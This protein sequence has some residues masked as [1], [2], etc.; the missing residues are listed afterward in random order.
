MLFLTKA[1]NHTINEGG[2]YTTCATTL[3]DSDSVGFYQ[4]NE[5]YTI[6][7]CSDGSLQN[8]SVNVGFGGLFSIDPSDTL[9]IYDGN[10]TSAPL[11]GAYNNDN[12][13]VGVASSTANT[14]GCLTFHFVSDGAVTDTGW[15]A[16]INCVK[17]CQPIEPVITTTPA[18][19]NYG[20][21]SSY[22][23]ICPDDT[24]FFSA[25]GA[26]PH[27]GINAINYAQS[28]ATSTFEWAFGEGT[29]LTAQTGS[30][31]YSE[32]GYAVLLTVTD[33]NN[34]QEQIIHKIR[35]G[36]TPSF[37]GISVVPDTACFGD[38]VQLNGGFNQIT[39]AGVGFTPSTGAITAGGTVT[40]QT[41]LPDGDGN[42]YSTSVSISGFAGQNI[43][44][45]TDIAEVCMNIEHSYLGDLQF[46]LTCPNGTT[47]MLSDNYNGSGGGTYLGDAFDPISPPQ[48]DTT[49]GVG[50]DYCFT[51]AATWGTM[52][53]ENL[54]S[55][56]IP[57][58]VTPGNNILSP[59][60]FQPEQSFNDLV[61]CPIDGNWTIT[62][63]DNLLSDNG[64]IFE[65]GLTL[66]PAI[67]PN[68]EFYNVA[69]ADGFWQSSPDI[70]SM[71]DTMA[72]AAPQT[73]GDNQYTFQI[74]DEYGCDFDTTV[75]VFV[76]Q[77][78][79][80][81]ATP[82]TTI[83]GSQLVNLN[84]GG[85]VSTCDYTV[86]LH[87]D[88]GDGWN[89][90]LVDI[91]INGVVYLGAQTVLDCSGSECE[92]TII[93]PVTTGDVISF[94]YTSGT[95]DYENTITVFDSEG[96][97][98]F[99]V[100]DPPVGAQGNIVADCAGGLGFSWGP[101][102]DLSD[103]TLPNPVFNGLNTQSYAVTMF[104][105]DHPQ[106][107]VLSDSITIEVDNQDLPIIT[108]DSAV[109][110][111]DPVSFLITGA[112]TITWPDNS[113]DSVYT[114][115]PLNDDIVTVTAS[116]VCGSM[117][118]NKHV[119]VYPE[120]NITAS[121]DTVVCEGSPVILNLNGILDEC[122]FLLT[123]ID[124]AGNG[125]AG[126]EAVDVKING[127]IYE[128]GVAVPDCNGS[129]CTTS[130]VIP[131]NG[132]DVI[133]LEYI[134]GATDNENTVL[135]FDASNAELLNVS[136]PTAGVIGTFNAT[137][138]NAYSIAWTPTTQLSDPTIANP[139]FSSTADENYQASVQ[140]VADNNCSGSTNTITMD[141]RSIE[142]PVIT[143]DTT[144]CIEESITLSINADSVLWW[145][146]ST[147]VNTS[148]TFSP[149]AD[150]LITA[151]ASTFCVSN[152]VVTHFV[153][154]Y[155]LPVINTINDTTITIQ[156]IVPLTTSGGTNYYWSPE[157]YLSCIICDSP[158]ASPIESIQ[159]TVVVEDSNGCRSSKLI[160]IEVLIPDL[161]I[162]TGFSP[163]G[164]GV[165]DEVFVRSLSIAT[166]NLQI[167]D[168]WG[169]LVFET[170]N[171]ERGW[172]G[173]A[174]G[175]KLDAGV[176]VYK[177]E[178]QL[179]SGEKVEQA[180]N[181]TLFR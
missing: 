41:F 120:I 40:G 147:Y 157:E 86:V 60:D 113:N 151:T 149:Q 50:M 74:T 153:E 145:G 129:I 13:P 45:G 137:C 6:T 36:L 156:Q 96:V 11:I 101:T 146:D 169:G 27:N 175:S 70:I 21:D 152:A 106:C 118:W 10:S 83:C 168:R 109:C 69:I 78:L 89:S 37:S 178:A 92:E 44:T 23:N 181:I 4:D 5:S 58:T 150:T 115:T 107:S 132:G 126:F 76:L 160:S 105:T 85:F 130:L 51:L 99:M 124:S 155:P 138:S 71:N 116:T 170:D 67:N 98:V 141:V 18:L 171:Q 16:I 179:V 159:Y 43:T 49:A 9:Y 8:N 73:E 180:G 100:N 123:L 3:Y 24:V 94:S 59:G 167:Y 79:T 111:G 22:T 15:I 33:A 2:S 88:F 121:P 163:N 144:L 32:G 17:V 104:L 142:N 143:G 127:I 63:T 110:F 174:K 53:D 68:A 55:N 28:D 72:I 148:F 19:V 29:E 31:V 162:P 61:G 134:S 161:F 54:A 66:N 30:A 48:P 133:T 42:S 35:T 46:E 91:L 39:N 125:W 64:Y 7:F 20:P 95:Y 34:C 62:V 1:Q 14:S 140:L 65:W 25:S 112:D 26:Y 47:I 75:N 136:T 158:E 172:D 176:Y 81:V 57:S 166:M 102:N 128:A 77:E 131:I 165:N 52:S 122:T 97:E 84:V 103:P 93:I 173:T 90:A 87:D 80:A 135:L 177:F 119:V 108:G 56:W 114:Y 164:D 139:I 117:T 38:T 154:V 12:P 82:D